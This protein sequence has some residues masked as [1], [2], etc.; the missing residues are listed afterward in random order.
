[1]REIYRS[2]DSLAFLDP[3]AKRFLQEG[4]AAYQNLSMDD[5]LLFD[6]GSE[7][8]LLTWLGDSANEALACLLN[9]QGVKTQ[10]SRLGV[11]ITKSGRTLEEVMKLVID[12]GLQP[13]PSVDQLLANA[14]NLTRQK[15]D[16]LLSP[17]LLRN[18][19]AS[20][21]LDLHEAAAWLSRLSVS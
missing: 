16:W 7:V 19:Y 4:Q 17:A 10:S 1:M 6:R 18:T 5:H 13:T 9:A 15:W 20:L 3:T 21:N 14:E 2:A 8:L 12:L 11:E